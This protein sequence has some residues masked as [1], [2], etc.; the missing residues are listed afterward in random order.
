MLVWCCACDEMERVV[1]TRSRDTG[2]CQ[3]S[4][5]Q[6]DDDTGS[7]CGMPLIYWKS[8]VTSEKAC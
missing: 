2:L 7:R 8:V 5:S 3:F 4:S 6:Q 1:S